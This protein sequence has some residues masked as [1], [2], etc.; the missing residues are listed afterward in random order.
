ME[1]KRTCPAS[2]EDRKR[3]REIVEQHGEAQ[4]VALTGIPRTTLDRV[5]AALPVRAGTQ[6]V[7]RQALQE[8]DE[9]NRG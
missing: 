6:I 3:L 8:I 4:A 5:L 1:T 7:L 2:I 9:A